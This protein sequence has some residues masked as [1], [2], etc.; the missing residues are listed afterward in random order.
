MFFISKDARPMIFHKKIGRSPSGRAGT[1]CGPVFID[2]IL[3]VK[4]RN[5]SPFFV[6]LD[7]KYILPVSNS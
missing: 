6:S 4:S 2:A 1:D 7:E 5:L 3:I